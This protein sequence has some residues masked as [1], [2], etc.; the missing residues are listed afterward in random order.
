MVAAVPPVSGRPAQDVPPGP[1]HRGGADGRGHRESQA[2]QESRGQTAQTDGKS[3]LSEKK[4]KKNNQLVCA[5]SAAFLTRL[6]PSTAEREGPREEG[7]SDSAQQTGQLWRYSNT[8]P[9]YSP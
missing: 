3:A 8:D 2:E 5:P 6:L 9:I 7:A 4:Q 1:D